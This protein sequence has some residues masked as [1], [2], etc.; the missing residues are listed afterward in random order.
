MCSF[1]AART[2]TRDSRV[3]YDRTGGL[4]SIDGEGG[5][6]RNLTN[7]D[8][9]REEMAHRW[10]V[11][12]TDG[13]FV[14]FTSETRTGDTRLEVVDTRD[15]SRSVVEPDAAQALWASGDRLIFVRDGE[16]LSA[17][18]DAGHLV[19]SPTVLVKDVT[20]ENS[21]PGWSAA[22]SDSGTLVMASEEFVRS[23]L[24]WVS[25]DGTERPITEKAGRFDNPMMSPDGRFIVYA[26]PAGVWRLD[27][28]RGDSTLVHEG[29]FPVWIDSS[30]IAF[31]TTNGVAVMRAD[32]EGTPRLLPGTIPTDYPASVSP[33][34][35]R[36][37]VVRVTP[38]S[39]GD[40]ALLAIEGSDK[41]DVFVSTR[42]YEGGA[43]F[44]PDGHWLA[45]TSDES[46]EQE[47]YLRPYPTGDQRW[48]VSSGGGI[49]PLWRGDSRRIFYRSGLSVF[50]VDVQAGAGGVVLSSPTRLFTGPY[51]IG[52]NITIP[53]YSIA[54]DGKRLVMVRREPGA[55]G[56]EVITNWLR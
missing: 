42:A 18:L 34:G 1:S 4:T 50:A 11:E 17:T 54:A 6:A 7:Y 8:K 37:A 27:L 52:G 43:Q 10:P 33:D 15:G 51:K 26:T 38:A 31:N 19:G 24:V 47:V 45:Y 12:S 13:R 14:F 21:N 2:W 53:N 28:A 55:R 48:T 40:V 25:E 3:L 5:D 23:R 41:P 46:G 29:A 32:G 36:L 39:S 35:T 22:V 20:K 30:R 9:S 44:S 56:L 49:H 16:I